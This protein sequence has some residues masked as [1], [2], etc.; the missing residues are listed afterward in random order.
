MLSTLDDAA[1]LQ[2]R[3]RRTLVLAAAL[4]A[5]TLSPLVV[6]R[7]V[8][9]VDPDPSSLLGARS[10][11][12]GWSALLGAL[13]ASA[14]VSRELRG[15][16]AAGGIVGRSTLA[17]IAYPA[18][19]FAP[20]LVARP[21]DGAAGAVL[22]C[23]FAPIVLTIFGAIFSVPAGAS[24]GAVF[25]SGVHLAGGSLARPAH[26]AVAHARSCG[27]AMLLA[28][29]GLAFVLAA[30][31]EGPYCQTLFFTVLPAVDVVPPEGTDAAWTRFLFLPAPLVAC[32]LA[33]SLAAFLERRRIARTVRALHDGTH[34]L[35]I[36]DGAIDVSAEAV[37]G[38][39]PLRAA[40]RRATRPLA[41]RARHE[42]SA[43]R[44][45]TAAI[46]SIAPS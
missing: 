5:A 45:G 6:A 1:T 25:W 4:S 43:Y 40:D 20:M 9:L 27:A 31:L 14:A 46:A 23:V 30:L 44:G 11:H 3:V 33:F 12:V 17:G 29:S 35:W 42:R 32:A 36:A 7:V 39:L 24:F 15:T 19:L 10:L 16:P 2:K 41:I 21:W 8:S 38:I 18:C 34:P 22:A 37:S 26:D 13:L 28:A